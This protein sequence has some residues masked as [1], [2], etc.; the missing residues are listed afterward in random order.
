MI[1]K[2]ISIAVLLSILIFTLAG[3]ENLVARSFEKAPVITYMRKGSPE[4]PYITGIHVYENGRVRLIDKANCTGSQY[5]SISKVRV[6]HFLDMIVRKQKFF[7]ITM[8][9]IRAFQNSREQMMDAATTYITVWCRSG[10]HKLS[11]YNF[12]KDTK[13]RTGKMVRLRRIVRELEN[14][15]QETKRKLR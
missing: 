13:V 1:R 12:F 15:L 11:V 7:S 9:D 6:Q 5:I 8:D 2:M 10:N 14:L 4:A 3:F